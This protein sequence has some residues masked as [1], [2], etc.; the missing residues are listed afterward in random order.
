MEIQKR[1]GGDEEAGRAHAALKARVLEEFLLE[2]VQSFR[3][4]QALDGR[5]RPPLHLERQDDA[6]VYEPAVEDHVAGAAVA[7]VTTLLGPGEP[8][9]VAEDLQQALPRLA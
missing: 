1:L 4:G 7:V 6:G 8:E 5:H 9:F 2:R 3:A